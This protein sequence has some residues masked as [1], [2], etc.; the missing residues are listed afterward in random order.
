MLFRSAHRH[1]LALTLLRQ[2]TLP[3]AALARQLGYAN[4]SVFN[5]AFRRWT[6]QSPGRLRRQARQGARALSAAAGAP[7]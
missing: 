4:Q 5:Q 3:L 2:G 6:G 7:C 1:A